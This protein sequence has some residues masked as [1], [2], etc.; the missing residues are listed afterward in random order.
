MTTV[1]TPSLSYF[2]SHT[3]NLSILTQLDYPS[4]TLASLLASPRWLQLFQPAVSRSLCLQAP[5]ALH[6]LLEHTPT[7]MA[8]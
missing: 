3:H 6:S 4:R 2:I 7:P 1:S 8:T 5:H